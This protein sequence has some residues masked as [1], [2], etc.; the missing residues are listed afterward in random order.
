MVQADLDRIRE[1][2]CECCVEVEDGERL[3]S[4]RPH[5]QTVIVSTTRLDELELAERRLGILVQHLVYFGLNRGAMLDCDHEITQGASLLS[6][7]D[8]GLAWYASMQEGR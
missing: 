5:V 1:G 8:A 2:V 6:I 3:V 7:A 4:I